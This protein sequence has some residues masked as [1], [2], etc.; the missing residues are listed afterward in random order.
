MSTAICP[1][2]GAEYVAS[3]TIC[4]DCGVALEGGAAARGGL[5]GPR[6]EPGHDEVVYD[7][8]DWGPVERDELSMVMAAEGFAHR[9]EGGDLVV[10]QGAAGLVEELIDQLD[11]PDALE[12]DEGDDDGGAE[13]LSALY[14][15]SDVLMSDPHRGSARSELVDAAAA[16]AGVPLPYGLDR[17]T[18]DEVRLRADALAALVANDAG[19]QVDEENV[20]AAARSLRQA[21]QPLV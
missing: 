4:A 8:V 21:V 3:A 14:V 6:A 9:W 1:V 17:A 15:A 19:D 2:C 13:V 7:L 10:S 5:G 11:H 12:V 16:A 18:W 20:V